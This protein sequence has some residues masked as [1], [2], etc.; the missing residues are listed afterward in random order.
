MIKIKKLLKKINQK[1]KRS[2]GAFVRSITDEM[3]NAKIEELLAA[4]TKK[5]K[6]L[7]LAVSELDVFGGLMGRKEFIAKLKHVIKLV[8]LRKE[9]IEASI[10]NRKGLPTIEM[11][12]NLEKEAREK[13]E[14]AR[15]ALSDTRNKEL[16]TAEGELAAFKRIKEVLENER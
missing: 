14:R 8:E 7:G 9:W 16:W 15:R 11:L 12:L 3:V 13:Y 6:D 2:F 4:G 1:I 10:Y 5:S